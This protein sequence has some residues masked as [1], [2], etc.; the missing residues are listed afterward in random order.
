MAE[1][2]AASRAVIIEKTAQLKTLR[3]AKEATEV[4]ARL[5]PSFRQSKSG[6]FDVQ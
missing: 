4:E 2:E 5:R 3:L 1:Y 6:S